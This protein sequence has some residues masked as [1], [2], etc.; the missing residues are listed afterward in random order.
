MMGRTGIQLYALKFNTHKERLP[1]LRDT[2][3][4]LRELCNLQAD[5]MLKYR[6]NPF[7][8]R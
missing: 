6:K 2:C 8:F 7:I 3:K 1:G 4:G 5:P